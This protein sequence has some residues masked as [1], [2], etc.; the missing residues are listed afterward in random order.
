M[1]SAFGVEH[2]QISKGRTRAAQRATQAAKSATIAAKKGQA[3]VEPATKKLGWKL[4]TAI[5]GAATVGGGGYA[6]AH[7]KRTA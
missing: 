7:R 4:P 1:R 3:A 2:G 6:Y 5:G